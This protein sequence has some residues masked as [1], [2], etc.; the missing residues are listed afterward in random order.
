MPSHLVSQHRC[1]HCTRPT[2]VSTLSKI[3][4]LMSDLS[5]DPPPPIETF[6]EN[7]RTLDLSPELPPP[8]P[9]GGSKRGEGAPGTSPPPSDQIFLNF[10]QL[11]RKI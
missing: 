1:A 5:S 7:P 8:S 10:M 3:V 11:L 2:F 9:S 4:F 6:M